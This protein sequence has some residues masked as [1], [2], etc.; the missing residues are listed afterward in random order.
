[1]TCVENEHEIIMQESPRISSQEPPQEPQEPIS[2]PPENDISN[3]I[4]QMFSDYQRI[5]L[6]GIV[7]LFITLTF[8]FRTTIVFIEPITPPE[9]YVATD[10]SE[11]SQDGLPLVLPFRYFSPQ[12]FTEV[13]LSGYAYILD[14]SFHG[15]PVNISAVFEILL[16][17]IAVV[18]FILL[19]N[20][21]KGSELIVLIS[22]IVGLGFGLLQISG[23]NLLSILRPERGLRFFILIWGV[24][25]SFAL[26]EYIRVT[27]KTSSEDDNNIPA[28]NFEKSAS[29]LHGI[30][31][32]DAFFLRFLINHILMLGGIALLYFSLSLN[33]YVFPSPAYPFADARTGYSLLLLRVVRGFGRFE[34][35]FTFR[36]FM[37]LLVPLATVTVST[38]LCRNIKY[39][40][41][42]VLIASIVGLC[43]AIS[44]LA[45]NINTMEHIGMGQW[46]F[47]ALWIPVTALAILEYRGVHI[48][49]KS[50]PSFE[51]I[52]SGG[53]S[54]HENNCEDN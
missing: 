11:Y 45:R 4:I 18:A 1:M 23:I 27:V 40:N 43:F 10:V 26:W 42:I 20:K 36:D 49:E 14:G 13:T 47:I 5:I 39:G 12:P 15:L 53:D 52:I 51:S 54:I 28:W 46:L 33:F 2:E 17:A 16:P 29:K 38:L 41:L 50:N 24:I 35:L 22:A 31:Y 7:L 9:T 6:V 44:P 34:I 19:K 8:D 37:R 48:F 30:S 25:A 3:G 21:I 32:F